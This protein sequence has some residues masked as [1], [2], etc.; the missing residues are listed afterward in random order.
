MRHGSG[1]LQCL[2]TLLV[3]STVLC[4]APFAHA[5]SYQSVRN[6]YTISLP[7]DWTQVSGEV[8]A[9]KLSDLPALKGS[10]PQVDVD[11]VF[12]P[13]QSDKPLDYPYIVVEV[14]RYSELGIAQQVNDHDMQ[15]IVKNTTGLDP[16]HPYTNDTQVVE[17]GG[18]L[19]TLD[20]VLDFDANNH[21]FTCSATNSHSEV[22]LVRTRQW[23]YFGKD[24][25]VQVTLYERGKGSDRLRDMARAV[26][27]SFRYEIGREYQPAFT[28]GDAAQLAKQLV[29][30]PNLG[31]VVTFACAATGVLF[32]IIALVSNRRRAPAYQQYSVFERQRQP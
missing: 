18:E 31:M 26:A 27:G 12:H 25:L 21:R 30:A 7:E 5:W 14:Q 11:V 2:C 23:G 8:L 16:A 9:G 6:G 32:A 28:L 4:I 24:Q 17:G 22:G 29:A 20:G 1:Q 15:Q 3:A 19:E 10:N 13:K